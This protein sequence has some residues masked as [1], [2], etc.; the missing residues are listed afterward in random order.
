MAMT[1]AVRKFQAE[2]PDK[3]DMREWMKPA[4]EAATDL[5]AALPEVRLRRPGR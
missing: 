4:R 5:Q 3:S 2:N 1:G